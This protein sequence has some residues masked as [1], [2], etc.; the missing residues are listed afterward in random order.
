MRRRRRR[1]R[2]QPPPF[3][4]DS[5]EPRHIPCTSSQTVVASPDFVV[6]YLLRVFC[7]VC[8]VVQPASSRHPALRCCCWFNAENR[9]KLFEQFQPPVTSAAH[10]PRRRRAISRRP[11]GE[12]AAFAR[13]ES[14]QKGKLKVPS[15]FPY[16]R[17]FA[18][19]KRTRHYTPRPRHRYAPSVRDSFAATG[20]SFVLLALSR[21]Q[22]SVTRSSVCVVYFYYRIIQ[23]SMLFISLLRY[24]RTCYSTYTGTA[25]NFLGIL[26]V[27]C[28]FQRTFPRVAFA[29]ISVGFFAFHLPE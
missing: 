22:R 3:V 2:P 19:Y 9:V 21:R 5:L 13:A 29:R 27:S 24:C 4:P 18:I 15:L 26:R 1:R 6:Q 11:A 14:R 10:L 28:F 7:T 12:N 20:R 25:P 8:S 16:A 17:R 23:V